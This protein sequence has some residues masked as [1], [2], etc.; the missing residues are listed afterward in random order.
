MAVRCRCMKEVQ[1]LQRRLY[2]KVCG[3]L[4]CDQCSSKSLI[5]YIPD[6]DELEASS[7]KLAI[8]KIV[9]VR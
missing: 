8:I 5:V 6:D 7:A 1:I 2:C 9:G 4:V 3:V